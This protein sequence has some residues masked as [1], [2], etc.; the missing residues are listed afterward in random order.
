MASYNKKPS[1][2]TDLDKQARLDFSLEISE[3]DFSRVIFTGEYEIGAVNVWG[4]LS[5]YGPCK[6]RHFKSSI[7]PAQYISVLEDIILP[8]RNRD[9]NSIIVQV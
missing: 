6:M 3:M 2:L 4:S 1:P 8:M 9:E 5:Y 7:T